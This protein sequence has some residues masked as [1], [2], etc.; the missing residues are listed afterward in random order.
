MS[1][2]K[3][4]T[5]SLL[6]A[7]DN[8]GD[9]ALIAQALAVGGLDVA[10]ETV[11]DGEA[12]LQRLLDPD[13]PRPDLLLLDIHMP[14]RDGLSALTEVRG[15]PDLAD[16][17]IVMFTTSRLASDDRAAE[18]LGATTLVTK[19][20]GFDELARLLRRM[21]EFF[22]AER[23]SAETELSRSALVRGPFRVRFSA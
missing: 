2:A 15:H 21:V 3:L 8:P 12:L 19:P 14:R 7:D 20:F 4:Q 22:R 10:L 18:R 11:A 13:R 5:F 17:P 9:R 1:R 6:V 16:L 23:R